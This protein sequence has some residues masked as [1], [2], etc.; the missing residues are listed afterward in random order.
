MKK[1][2]QKAADTLM[3][4]I[5]RNS[6]SPATSYLFKKRKDA[7]LREEKSEN[8][9]IIVASLLFISSR[10]RLDIQAAVAFL[11]TKFRNQTKMTRKG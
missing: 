10:C 1:H 7:K 4:D 6:A 2:I 9:H 3:D 8:S 11:C 5:T